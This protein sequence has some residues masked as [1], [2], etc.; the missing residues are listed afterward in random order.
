VLLLWDLQQQSQ[1]LDVGEAVV[2]IGEIGELFIWLGAVLDFSN[3]LPGLY[4]SE[5]ILELEYI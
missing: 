2:T 1:L 3:A 4:L 5:F